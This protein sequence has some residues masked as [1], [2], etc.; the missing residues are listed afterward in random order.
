MAPAKPQRVTASKRLEPNEPGRALAPT[1]AIDL[2]RSKRATAFAPTLFTA[3]WLTRSP[4]SSRTADHSAAAIIGATIPPHN[5][6]SVAP[7]GG[8]SD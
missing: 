4:R 2:G 1:T 7:R 8:D 3:L 6:R 5:K